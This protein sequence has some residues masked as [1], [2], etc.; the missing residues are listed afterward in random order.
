MTT[1][2]ERQPLTDAQRAVYDYIESYC[3]HHGYGPVIREIC[4]QFGY[5][6][7]NG[8]MCHLDPLR[9]KGWVTWIDGQAR[10]IQPIGGDA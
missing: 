1:T 4:D 10:T 5:K 2:L 3:R 8:A 6:S 9:R 7:P